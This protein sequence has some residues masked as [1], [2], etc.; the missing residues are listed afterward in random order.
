MVSSCRRGG[1]P[2]AG[3]LKASV[4]WEGLT[5]ERSEEA[6]FYKVFPVLPP[7]PQTPICF[8]S[9]RLAKDFPAGCGPALARARVGNLSISGA[10]LT[11]PA[12]LR[13][14]RCFLGRCHV[15]LCAPWPPAAGVQ[16]SLSHRAGQPE[17]PLHTVRL[18]PSLFSHLKPGSMIPWQELFLAWEP[19]RMST[20]SQHG[21]DSVWLRPQC[22]GSATF[23]GGR[24][25]GRPGWRQTCVSFSSPVTAELAWQVQ[26]RQGLPAAHEDLSLTARPLALVL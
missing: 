16:P 10:Q 25:R 3:S 14:L 26:G 18:F 6:S 8:Q 11:C 20:G 15:G 2:G 1:V 24:R 23:I 19:A 9:T 22:P 4:M 5:S 12:E 21:A 13:P 17:A 7:K